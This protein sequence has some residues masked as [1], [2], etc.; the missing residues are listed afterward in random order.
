MIIAS[1]DGTR[2]LFATVDRLTNDAPS[3]EQ[4]IKIYEFDA[5]T[6]VVRYLPN[7]TAP[8][9]AASSNGSEFLFEDTASNPAKLVIWDEGVLTPISD[10]TQAGTLFLD[11]VRILPFASTIIFQTNA[12]LSGGFNSGEGLQQIYIYSTT[13]HALSCLSCPPAGI[14]PSGDAQLSNDDVGSSGL[15]QP[16]DANGVTSDGTRVFFDSPDP[17]VPKD[18][19]GVRDVY[20]WNAGKISLISAGTGP[21]GSRYLDNTLS[22]R[23]VFFATADDLSPDDTDG[24]YD[25]YDATSE[26][27]GSE[28]GVRHCPGGCQT[29]VN[30]TVTFGPLAGTAVYPGELTHSAIKKPSTVRRVKRK[31]HGRRGRR[32]RR[33]LATRGRRS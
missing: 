24:G 12:T 9:L 20:E 19:N 2:A 7:V 1:K 26:G 17:L 18:I 4:V 15:G 5:I 30:G 33:A 32:R 29:E 25:V 13:R 27:G 8:V 6:G 3:S 21:S 22:G 11:P 10:I 31:K 28:G 23:D 16:R 14:R